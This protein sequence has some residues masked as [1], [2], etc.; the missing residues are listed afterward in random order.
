MKTNQDIARI[1]S[2]VGDFYAMQNVPFKPRAYEKAAAGVADLDTPVAEILKNEG[3]KGLL[4]IAGVGPGIAEH[5]VEIVKTGKLKLYEKMRHKIPVRLGELRAVPGLGPKTVRELYEKLEIRNLAQLEDALKKG[6]IR[7]LQGFGE[8]SE[9]KIAE[10]IKFRRDNSS[11]FS[12]GQVEPI[13]QK[14][15]R[16]LKESGLFDEILIA[17]SYRRRQET[18]GDLDMLAVARDPKKAMDFFVNIEDAVARVKQGET[19]SE[20]RVRGGIKIDLRIVPPGA[21]GAAAIYFTGDQAHN[22]H[23]RNI[24]I[25]KG[26]KLSE[27]GLTPLNPPSR[28]GKGRGGIVDTEERVYKALGMDFIPPEMRTDTGEIEAARRQV[29]GKLGGLPDLIP[30]DSIK[31]DLQVQTDWTD[32]GFSIEEMARAAMELGREYIA[33]TDHTKTLYMTGGLDEKKLARQGRE[34]DKI[35]AK[36]RPPSLRPS[37]RKRGEGRVRGFRI[38]KG[39][40][41]NIQKDGALDIADETLAKL[42]VV[43]VS[44]HSN[45]GMSAKDMTERIIRAISNPNVDIFFHPTTRIINRRPPIDFD[46]DAVLRAAKKYGVALEINAHPAR[47]DL[48]DTLI[49]KAVEA[50]VRLVID[51][52][53]HHVEE[54]K[55]LHFGI[56]QARRGWATKDD[57]LNTK[58]VEEVLKYFEKK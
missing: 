36:L 29:Q 31:G 12:L 15:Y 46:F 48:H 22:I 24:A 1:L 37:P 5:L 19:R 18:V 32:G 14:I 30:Y 4:K 27:Y 54:L 35:N 39:A 28:G 55:N 20:I 6:K 10:S 9:Q 26:Y 23:L 41:V 53:A 8:K 21:W 34:I 40:E 25:K 42:D 51:S 50:G 52:D 3:E 49:R 17:G 43:G 44:V 16:R 7:K 47:L 45:F 13:A 38:L 2:E 58:P 11:R 56:A 33:I 57:V